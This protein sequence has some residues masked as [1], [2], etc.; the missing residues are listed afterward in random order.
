MYGRKST[1]NQAKIINKKFIYNYFV[2]KLNVW[3]REH[4]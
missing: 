3:G 1:A 2:K 4:S